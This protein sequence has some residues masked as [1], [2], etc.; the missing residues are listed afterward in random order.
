MLINIGGRRLW[1]HAY[2]WLGYVWRMAGVDKKVG[3]GLS[4]CLFGRAF[5]VSSHGAKNDSFFR[6]TVDATGWASADVKK[7]TLPPKNVLLS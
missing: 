3:A 5:S 7:L 4:L 1:F 6:G 2:F